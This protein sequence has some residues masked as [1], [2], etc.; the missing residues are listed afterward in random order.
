MANAQGYA[1]ILRKQNFYILARKEGTAVLFYLNM[2]R[3]AGGL[4]RTL[5]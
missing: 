4:K 1:I 5:K 2:L 3:L